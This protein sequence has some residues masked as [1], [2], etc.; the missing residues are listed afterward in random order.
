MPDAKI[1]AVRYLPNLDVNKDLLY[2]IAGL[3]A[4]YPYFHVGEPLSF[5]RSLYLLSQHQ[6]VNAVGIQNRLEL[7]LHSER[8]CLPQLLF[9]FVTWCKSLNIPIDYALLFWNLHSW[10]NKDKWVQIRWANE[11]Y[12]N[13][14]NQEE[15][16]VA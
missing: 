8:S 2:A 14:D 5:G 7:L 4:E 3:I 9:N 12:F 15:D 16:N 11:F 13:E 1:R 10:D 6:K